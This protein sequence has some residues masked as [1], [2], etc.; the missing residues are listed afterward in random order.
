MVMGIEA[1]TR[2]GGDI[3][4]PVLQTVA[5]A[6][7]GEICVP[8]WLA[9]SVAGTVAGAMGLMWRAS[10]RRQDRIESWIERLLDRESV[11]GK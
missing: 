8:Y 4:A 11:N 10:E 1:W 3:V 7:E 9:L 5:S 6:P 2:G